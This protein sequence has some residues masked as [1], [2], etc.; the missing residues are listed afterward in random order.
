MSDRVY[1]ILR[2]RIEH[3]LEKP[4]N[5][6]PHMVIFTIYTMVFGLIGF[7]ADPRVQGLV[8][9]PLY[10]AIFIGSLLVAFHTNY[11]YSRSG[12][13][14]KVRDKA[15]RKEIVEA[16]DEFSLVE[17]EMVDL[18]Q[19]LSDDIRERSKIFNK[20]AG[21]AGG[22]VFLWQGSLVLLFLFARLPFNFPPGFYTAWNFA[23]FF[24]TLFLTMTLIP[25]SKLMP[26][27]S[28]DE[29]LNELYQGKSKRGIDQPAIEINDEGEI[30]IEYEEKYRQ[31]SVKG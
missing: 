1:S 2:N 8:Q 29:N 10:L 13:W 3:H 4:R 19:R 7:V 21:I 15:I 24:G 26:Q 5:L 23:V 28:T 27:G 11:V 20:L 31:N 6:I 9:S 14:K 25:W 30:L 22:Y 12:A 17:A 16:S 18:H